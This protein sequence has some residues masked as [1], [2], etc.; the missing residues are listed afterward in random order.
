MENSTG[1]PQK[2]SQSPLLQR[3]G[4]DP[5]Q[6]FLPVG[7]PCH[8]GRSV[9]ENK[10]NNTRVLFSLKKGCGSATPETEAGG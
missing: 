10:L 2:V 8:N 9:R 1:E 6:A 7:V 4:R 5:Q 3:E